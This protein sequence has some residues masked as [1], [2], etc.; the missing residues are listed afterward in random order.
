MNLKILIL[1]YWNFDPMSIVI[2]ILLLGFQVWSN[3]R[4]SLRKDILFLTGIF[5]MLLVTLSPL[6]Y[7][8]MGYLFSA[9]M[10]EHIVMLL[11]VPPLLLAGTNAGILEKLQKSSFHG[12]GKFLFSTPIAWLIGM[13]AMYL[14]HIPFLFHVMKSSPFIHELHMIS[15]LILGVIFIWPVY[16]PIPW[17]RLNP[18]Q[19]ALYLFIACVG[20]TV[21]GILISFSPSS[22]YIPYFTGNS[23]AIWELVR[24]DWGITPSIDQQ[25]G[26]LIMWVPACFIYITNVM[27]ILAGYYNQRDEDDEIDFKPVNKEYEKRSIS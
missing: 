24:N 18:L 12:I 19:S 7:L 2:A 3:R 11:V 15:L 26:G 13:G 20:C 27:V 5:L 25:A 17:K 14:W 10:I 16:A 22:L 9:H 4:G 1:H 8:S 6:G 21:L 23:D